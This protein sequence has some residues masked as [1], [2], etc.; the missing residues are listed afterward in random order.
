MEINKS[1][2]LAAILRRL[3]VASGLTQEFVASQLKMSRSTYSYYELGK[4][5]PSLKTITILA[6]MF[7]VTVE[8]FFPDERQLMLRDSFAKGNTLN[9]SSKDLTPDERQLIAIYRLINMRDKRKIIN[10]IQKRQPK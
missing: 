10:E 8:E 5:E 2:S 9:V 4:T 1:N 6:K 7:G 3:R